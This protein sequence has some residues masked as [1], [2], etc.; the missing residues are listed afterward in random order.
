MS[1]VQDIL[2]YNSL[3]YHEDLDDALLEVAASQG[4]DYLLNQEIFVR[5]LGSRQRNGNSVVQIFRPLVM[6][7]SDL[8]GLA[9]RP[10]YLN[11]PI[12]EFMYVERSEIVFHICHVN[13]FAKL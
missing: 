12:R 2:V 5:L 9:S 10:S 11:A 1:C 13:E 7:T 4:F 6:T 3:F 8:C